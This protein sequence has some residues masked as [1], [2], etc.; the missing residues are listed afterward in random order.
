[1]AGEGDEGGGGG[2][3]EGVSYFIFL[4]LSSSL[5]KAKNYR[6]QRYF[7]PLEINEV[8]F[9]SGTI[10]F[11]YINRKPLIRAFQQYLV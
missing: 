9:Y 6:Y 7:V 10:A 1:M 2:G 11:F 8:L 3:W 5:G 4:L